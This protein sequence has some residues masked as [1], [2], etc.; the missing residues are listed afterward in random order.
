M[1]RDEVERA[2]VESYNR[3]EKDKAVA[4]GIALRSGLLMR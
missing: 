1:M 3:P 2:D 4:R